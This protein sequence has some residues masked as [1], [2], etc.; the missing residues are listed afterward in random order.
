MTESVEDNA[1]DREL[2]EQLL[3]RHVIAML[4][5][6]KLFRRKDPRYVLHDSLLETEGQVNVIR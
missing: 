2:H 4:A 3:D 6:R 5:S 1:V